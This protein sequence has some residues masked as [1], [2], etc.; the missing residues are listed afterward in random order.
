MQIRINKGDGHVLK[1]SYPNFIAFGAFSALATA[2][3][4]N[5]AL[6]KKGSASRIKARTIAKMFRILRRQ[7]RKPDTSRIASVSIGKEISI[8]I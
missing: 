8:T 6:R 5:R 3:K 4:I 2:F 1:L 7:K